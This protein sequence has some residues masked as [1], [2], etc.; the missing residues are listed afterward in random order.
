[1][2][3]TLLI[4]S[5]LFSPPPPPPSQSPSDSAT[6]SPPPSPPLQSPVSGLPSPAHS[7]SNQVAFKSILLLLL[8]VGVCSFV[9]IATTMKEA[10]DT[11]ALPVEETLKNMNDLFPGFKSVLA[12]VE[13]ADIPTVSKAIKECDFPEV[14]SVLKQADIPGAIQILKEADLPG[15][16]KVFKASDLPGL[17]EVLKDSDIPGLT[18]SVTHLIKSGINFKILGINIAKASAGKD[19]GSL[20]RVLLPVSEYTRF[21]NKLSDLQATVHGRQRYEEFYEKRK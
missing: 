9:S 4:I 1:M 8:G 7:F 14:T 11:F 6:P 21:Q 20:T 5:L 19:S 17:T 16:A 10:F 18:K 3:L 15:V 13:Q 2:S 12:T